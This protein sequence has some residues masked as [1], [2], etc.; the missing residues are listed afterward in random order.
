[1][2][3]RWLICESLQ[4]EVLDG[5]VVCIK[6]IINYAN[7]SVYLLYKYNDYCPIL[8]NFCLQKDFYIPTKL[9]I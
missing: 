3:A 5:Y 2:F 4:G 8:Y 1:M 9:S 6:E 7:I